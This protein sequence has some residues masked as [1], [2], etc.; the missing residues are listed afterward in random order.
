MGSADGLLLGREIPPRVEEEHV[1]GFCQVQAHATGLERDEE[2]L[3]VGSLLEV[4]DD[5]IAVV[6]CA[7]EH[8][9]L[10]VQGLHL[11]FDLL[12]EADV[13]AEDE[14][15]MACSVKFL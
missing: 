5:F 7:G 8:G 11:S 4:G 2:E 6:A 12:Q 1:V 9:V 15:L 13:L 10:P 14:Y 3:T